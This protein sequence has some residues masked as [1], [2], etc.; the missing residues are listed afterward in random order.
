MRKHYFYKR[1]EIKK[2]K[3]ERR[4]PVYGFSIECDQTSLFKM[5]KQLDLE[6]DWI[7]N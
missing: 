4:N 7:F 1:D 5:I 3:E 2:A 6:M